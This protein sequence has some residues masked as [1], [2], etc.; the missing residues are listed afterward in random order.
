MRMLSENEIEAILDVLPV[1]ITF[2]DGDD[3][4]RYFNK[5]EG[6]I[7]KRSKSVIG[8]KVQECH[9]QKSVHVVNRILE[10]FKTRERD[11]AEFW[12]GQNGR[13]IY[14]RYLPVRGKEGKYLGTIEVTQ[15]ITN[16][17]RIAGEKRLLDWEG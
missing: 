8:M 14:I 4:I 7:F 16:V 13:L 12:I 11:V 9:P 3:R 10:G 2:I 1:D 6:R 5:F 17:R 15:D